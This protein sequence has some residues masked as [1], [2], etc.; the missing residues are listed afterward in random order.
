MKTRII[1]TVVAI[2]IAIGCNQVANL[3]KKQSDA[4]DA[5][6]NSDCDKYQACGEIAAGKKY[7]NRSDCE[8]EARAYWNDKW[9]VGDCDGNINGNNLDICTDSITEAACTDMDRA[10]TSVFRCSR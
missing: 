7:A 4:L 9:P 2:V 1:G 5:V 8:A 6:V 10:A 3:T